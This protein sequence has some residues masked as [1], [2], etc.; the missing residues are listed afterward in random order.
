MYASGSNE[1][2]IQLSC[3]IAKH[4]E[5]MHRHQNT[6]LSLTSELTA[7]AGF[8]IVVLHKQDTCVAKK[9]LLRIDISLHRLHMH[10]LPSHATQQLG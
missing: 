3:S 1:K 5:P 6:C 10:K 2:C 9:L 7:S 4:A 8:A